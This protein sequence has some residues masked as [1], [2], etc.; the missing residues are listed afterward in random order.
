[1]SELHQQSAA[2]VLAQ[3]RDGSLT[4]SVLL[5][6]TLARI[7]ELNP[8]YG[9]FASLSPQSAQARAAFL[10]AQDHQA[11]ALPATQA[12]STTRVSPRTQTLPPA[13]AL[14]GLPIA[15]K[16]LSDRA[17]MPTR[18]GSRLFS[19][20]HG[21][22]EL[23]PHVNS[24]IAQ[25]I[26]DAGGISVGKTST[27]EFGL[28][29]Y[30]E[31][32]AGPIAKNPW[33]IT[34]TAG[35]SSGGAAVAV[36]SGMLHCAP[37]S[38]GGGSI[39]IPAAACGLVGLKPTRGLIA[40]AGGV[41]S[42]GGLVTAGPI[43]RSVEDA[44]VLLEGLISREASGQASYHYSLRHP[45]QPYGSYLQAVRRATSSGEVPGQRRP[46]RLAVSM[47]S[48]WDGFYDISPEK[49]AVDALDAAV[50]MLTAAL[51]DA[52]YPVDISQ[53]LWEPDP[54]YAP[55]FRTLWMAAAAAILV[56]E[57]DK[58]ALLEPLTSWL[59]HQG[60][61]L[62][63]RQLV[64]A[65]N[66]AGQFERRMVHRLSQ[67][68]AVIM[69]ALGMVPPRLGH[70]DT[71]DGERNFEQQCRFTPYTSA[72]NASG[73]PAITLPTLWT[74]AT[75]TAVAGMPM[76]VQLVGRPGSETTLLALAC[77]L[78]Q[79]AGGP[80]NWPPSPITGTTADTRASA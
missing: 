49:P 38:D 8:I 58:M 31:P 15:D 74:P 80:L 18:Y 63:A 48:G 44:A 37:G 24:D 62:P 21:G 65:L 32:L 7:A 60:R 2:D 22:Q 67:V 47:W 17:G 72:W 5:S 6:H 16:D 12:A 77:L 41:N 40:A 14:W 71:E 61:Q 35:G 11:Q 56:D 59:M 76:G 66:T 13:Q 10:E 28:P 39:R 52:G 51:E 64:Q 75:E 78:E 69:P 36:A 43:A 68:D 57:P 1:M 54:S 42:L 79:R 53:P 73:L 20:E 50:T 33:D 26:D 23:I 30:T 19:P 9:A 25:Q 70:F 45:A 3:L 55:M 29:A 34:R 4:P 27:P 46:I